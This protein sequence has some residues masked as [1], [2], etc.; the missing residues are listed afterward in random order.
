MGKGFSSEAAIAVGFAV[1]SRGCLC[2]GELFHA[3]LRISGR[4]G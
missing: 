4:S 1:S 2:V 3:R